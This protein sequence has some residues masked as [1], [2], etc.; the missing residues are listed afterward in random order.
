MS[1]PI[2]AVVIAN[3]SGVRLLPKRTVKVGAK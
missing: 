1:K 2:I 3:K